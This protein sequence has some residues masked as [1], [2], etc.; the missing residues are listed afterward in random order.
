MHEALTTVEHVMRIPP[1]SIAASEPLS[2]AADLLC[3]HGLPGLPVIEGDRIVGVVTPF[4]L[5]RQPPDRRVADVMRMVT[6]VAPHLSLLQAH[7]FFTRQDLDV[8]PV[9]DEGRLVGLLSLTALLEAR[10]QATDP[11]TG[12]PWSTAL[13]AWAS[14]SLGRGHEVAILFVDLDN[15]HMVN[16]A[17]G[18]VAGDGVLRSIARRIGDLLDPATDLLC[19]YGGD[20]FA[21]ATTRGVVPAGA[22]AEQIRRGVVVP[23]DIGGTSRSIT[24]SVGIAG[25]RRAEKRG[26]AH[27][28]ATVEDLLALASRGST[29]A[30]SSGR[31]V[32]RYTGP[33]VEEIRRRAELPRSRDWRL[34]LAGITVYTA[35]GQSTA[36]VELSLGA[37]TGTGTAVGAADR[38][39]MSSLVAAATLQAITRTIG[40]RYAFSL[41]DLSEIPTKDGTLVVVLLAAESGTPDRFVGAALGSDVT[42][43][44]PKAILDGLNRRLVEPTAELLLRDTE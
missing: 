37:W 13:R 24:V 39:G 40:E 25:G 29:L 8:L 27:I 4:Q 44:V 3:Q 15:F 23:V 33:S 19:R 42:Q 41:E 38:R 35:S 28:T 26:A 6:P 21:I 34:R 20:E 18:H 11:M 9:V 1:V 22:L 30:K 2:A 14:V 17:L 43:A 7:A 31:G 5:L 12:L 16:R 32:V 36:S 10:S